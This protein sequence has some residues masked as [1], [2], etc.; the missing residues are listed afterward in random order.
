MTN[1]EFIAQL[2]A[3]LNTF[4][5]DSVKDS[6]IKYARIQS[7]IH[8]IREQMTLIQNEF[9]TVDKM[10]FLLE[11]VLS[12]NTIDK[13]IKSR[14]NQLNRVR[15]TIDRIKVNYLSEDGWDD[16]YPYTSEPTMFHKGQKALS[17][18]KHDAKIKEYLKL[19][20]EDLQ[21]DV[22]ELCC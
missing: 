2:R 4:L 15:Q 8:E 6:Q 19:N 3:E 10:S 14:T 12:D 16:F 1:E 11:R 21:K 5:V 17:G 9:N 20:L 18:K 22:E 7:Q 13:N